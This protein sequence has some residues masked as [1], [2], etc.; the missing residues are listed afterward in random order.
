MKFCSK[1]GKE[2]YDEAAFCPACGCPTEKTVNSTVDNAP[3]KDIIAI[4]EFAEKAT[5]IRN[6]GIIAAIL[7]F[8]I[9][10]IFSIIIWIKAPKQSGLPEVTTT[11]PVELAEFE[12]A[13]RKLSLG[14]TLSTLP[15]LGIALSVFIGVVA[16][17]FL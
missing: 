9:G 12:A 16:G 2:L 15:L 10:I 14:T 5:A 13:K 8:G 4:R 11:N 3:T 1:C 7:M 6:L 17:A